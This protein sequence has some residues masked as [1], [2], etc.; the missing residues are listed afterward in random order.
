MISATAAVDHGLV[1]MKNLGMLSKAWPWVE[2]HCHNSTAAIISILSRPSSKGFIKLKSNNPKDHPIIQPNYLTEEKDIDTLVAAIKFA[3]KL[4]ETEAFKEA[5]AEV[6]GPDPFCAH[7]P[8]KSD[9]Y[10]ECYVKHMTCT[11]YHPVGTCAM[12]TVLDH[13]L[14]V[15]GV[16]GLR[17]VDGSVMPNIV[18]GNTNA[19]IIMIA[20][21]GADMILHDSERNFKNEKK[22][23]KEEL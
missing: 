2:P 9:E 17:V 10:W 19:P 6:W 20:E 13:R 18:G 7:H 5:G 16:T 4:S 21:K 8:F 14:R 15:K 1:L 11:M 23:R 22:Q 3:V 12:G